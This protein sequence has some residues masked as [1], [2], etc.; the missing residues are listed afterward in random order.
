MILLFGVV[1]LGDPNGGVLDKLVWLLVVNPIA[2]AIFN[3]LVTLI[4]YAILDE[5]IPVRPL[6]YYIPLI[7][8][9]Y[10]VEVAV[11]GA[12]YLFLDTFS[13]MG[14]IPFFLAVF[15]VYSG[16]KG[17]RAVMWHQGCTYYK[18]RLKQ[19]RKVIFV[20]TIYVIILA[21]WVI[22]YRELGR[23]GRAILPFVL[24]V[25][26]F[27]FK[28][29]LLSV[30]DSFPI[31]IA[32]LI[33]GLWLENL[34]DVFQTIVFPVVPDSDVFLFFLLWLRKTAENVAYILFLTR[35]WFR[36]RVWIKAF[37]KRLFCPRK[38]THADTKIIREDVNADDRGH[39]NQR[40]GYWRRQI[41]FI[42]LKFFSQ[43]H[44][45]LHYLTLS[46]VLRHGVNRRFYP[47]NEA[48]KSD[49]AFPPGQYRNSILFAVTNLFTTA[50]IGVILLVLFAHYRR[51]AMAALRRTYESLLTTPVYMGFVI[52][53]LCSSSIL[54]TLVVQYHNR[55][56]FYSEG[57][58]DA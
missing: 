21:C 14:L 28:K 8:G 44:S 1:P 22:A 48:A 2:Y 37:L 33:A 39:G 42:S 46:P 45:N 40:P 4:F 51:H 5:H 12:L 43:V 53:I 52:A 26:V 18:D 41:M 55:I 38:V 10:V 31:T 49:H 47:V 13:L 29:I 50:V 35:G 6:R 9:T 25:I 58:P 7:I 32:M 56:W 11:M 30:T 17:M 19:Y 16:L 57:G 27:F 3:S 15:F 20:I 54:S 36:F 23:Q 34:D 24:L